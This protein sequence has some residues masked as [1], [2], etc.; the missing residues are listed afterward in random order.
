MFDRLQEYDG[1]VRRALHAV[2]EYFAPIVESYAKDNAPWIDRTGNARQ[3]LT[4]S[5]QDIS[6]TVVHLYL[7]HKMD[8]GVYLELKHSGRY[9]IILP[10]LEAHYGEIKKRL[11][12]IFSQVSHG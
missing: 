8:Y 1:S 2:A 7:S 12:S 9:A 6:Q 4:G 11:D 3:G 5:V 10:T